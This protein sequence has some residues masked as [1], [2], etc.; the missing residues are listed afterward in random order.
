MN[1]NFIMVILDFSTAA[2]ILILTILLGKV[3]LVVLLLVIMII[4]YE[5]QGAYQ[6]A[7]Q[8]SIPV[9]LLEEYIMQGNAV[10]NLVS[11][12]ASLLGPI[13][14]GTDYF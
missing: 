6:Q 8:A 12:L 11:S 3:N 1:K 10:I 5:I 4:L 2:L 9:L 14:G 13:V 7:V